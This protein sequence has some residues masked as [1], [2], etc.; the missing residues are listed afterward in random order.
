[1]KGFGAV[2]LIFDK[3]N[4]KMYVGQTTCTLERRFKEHAKADY[5]LSLRL[6]AKLLT[7]IILPMVAKIL[8]DWNVRPNIVQKLRRRI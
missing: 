7:V 4:G 2:Y 3:V 1:M 5:F 8:L 6:K